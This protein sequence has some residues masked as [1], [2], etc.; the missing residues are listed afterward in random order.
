MSRNYVQPGNYISFTAPRNLNGGDGC[1]LGSLFGVANGTA[2]SGTKVVLSFEGVFTLPKAAG[3]IVNV[4]EALYWDDTAHDLTVTATN[5]IFVGH[6]VS[7]QAGGD[8]TVNIRLLY[9]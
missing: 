4:G 7:A 6:A 9:S 2:A 5:N 8:S 3:D 1:L